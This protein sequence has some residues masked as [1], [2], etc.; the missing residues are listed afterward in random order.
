MTWQILE[1]SN[2]AVIVQCC[3][4]WFIIGIFPEAYILRGCSV[5][6]KFIPFDA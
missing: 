4:A 1:H 6:H 5:A 2:Y 3:I